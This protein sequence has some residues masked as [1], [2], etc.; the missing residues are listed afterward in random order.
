MR[1]FP[2]DVRYRLWIEFLRSNRDPAASGEDVWTQIESIA[3]KIV[4]QNPAADPIAVRTMIEDL[5]LSSLY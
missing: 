3:A 5:R 2:R 1:D 4:R